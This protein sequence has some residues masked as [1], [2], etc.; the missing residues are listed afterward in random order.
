[1]FSER[2]FILA[3]R[4]LQ[5]AT[6]SQ[7]QKNYSEQSQEERKKT[8]SNKTN[9]YEFYASS[10]LNSDAETRKASKAHWV[11]VHKEN[12]EKGSNEQINFSAQILAII[13]MAESESEEK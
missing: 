12:L 4:I 6:V 3:L 9:Y 11:K 10:Y 13:L 2:V 8:V 5:W 7:K 1:M